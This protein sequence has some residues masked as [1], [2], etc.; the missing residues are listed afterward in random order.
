MA[1]G[2]PVGPRSCLS[3]EAPPCLCVPATWNPAWGS[4]TLGPMRSLAGPPPSLR[5]AAPVLPPADGVH[6]DV[7]DPVSHRVRA[8]ERSYCEVCQVCW[9]RA[10]G[11]WEG[12][13]HTDTPAV[14]GGQ[15]HAAR[16]KLAGAQEGPCRRC[17]AGAARG[18]GSGDPQHQWCG[19][20]VPL[21][22]LRVAAS[23]RASRLTFP[24]VVAL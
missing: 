14:G 2:S 11:G 20:E 10:V 9:C 18:D 24:R 22:F 4:E 8:S 16:W 12:L 5:T 7:S 21:V 1:W 6:E 15:M 17:Q 13:G 3:A 23:L 19:P